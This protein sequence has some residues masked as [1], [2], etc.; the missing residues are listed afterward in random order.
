MKKRLPDELIEH[1]K[2]DDVRRLKDYIVK[3]YG[4]AFEDDCDLCHGSGTHDNGTTSKKCWRCKGKGYQTRE[5][6]ED[7]YAK[8]IEK[9][10]KHVQT[11]RGVNNG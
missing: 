5:D 6:F 9:I 7:N 4:G 10:V 2:R 8:D 11:A 1:L 3:Y